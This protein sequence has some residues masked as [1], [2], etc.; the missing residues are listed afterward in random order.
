MDCVPD[1]SGL[2]EQTALL[3]TSIRNSW[4]AIES[5]TD[6]VVSRHCRL[7]EVQQDRP[8][9]PL[10]RGERADLDRILQARQ[11]VLE[12]STHQ[13]DRKRVLFHTWFLSGLTFTRCSASRPVWFGPDQREWY[14]DVQRV[15]GHRIDQAWPYRMILVD[16]PVE[17][18]EDGGHILIIQHEH[19]QERGTLLSNFWHR[20][21][22]QLMLREA[23]MVPSWLF[24]DHLLAYLGLRDD[25][26]AHIYLCLGFVGAEPID[27]RLPLFP[28]SGSHV[29]IHTAEWAL[30][31]ESSLIQSVIKPA[32]QHGLDLDEGP[33]LNAPISARGLPQAFSLR[34]VHH[35]L[36]SQTS[37]RSY[38]LHSLWTTRPKI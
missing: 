23:H 26:R 21:H 18:Q 6:S 16:P 15:W 17:P 8:R 28:R 12:A 25:C 5:H 31:D 24:F 38:T 29:E 35:W 36:R 19:F 4:R 3:Q 30:I 32:R 20:D 1:S 14:D 33:G 37:R 11:R 27:E 7:D 34:P 10:D 13:G 9:T 22:S 2:N